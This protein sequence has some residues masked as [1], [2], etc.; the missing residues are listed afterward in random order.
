MLVNRYCLR[1]FRV[2]HEFA[3]RFDVNRM[4]DVS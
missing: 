3:A 4:A 1:Y 2:N